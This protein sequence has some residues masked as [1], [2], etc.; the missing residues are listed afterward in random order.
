MSGIKDKNL[1]LPSS[2]T[3]PRLTYN[4]LRQHL[5]SNLVG[6]ID[7]GVDDRFK[8]NLNWFEESRNFGITFV[9][10]T[11]N[12]RDNIV[13][14]LCSI[15]N[16]VNAYLKK[17]TTANTCTDQQQYN[18][19]PLEFLIIDNG[20]TDDT[21]ITVQS[22]CRELTLDFIDLTVCGAESKRTENA[23]TRFPLFVTYTRYPFRIGK[24]GLE[25]YVTP[26]N[27]VH[28]VVY[29]T[30]WSWM[31][32]CMQYVF[33]WNADF[34]M[35]L[36][37]FEKMTQT[38]KLGQ[39]DSIRLTVVDSGGVENGEY[40]INNTH[41]LPCLMKDGFW[42]FREFVLPLGRTL[43]IFA[44]DVVVKRTRN[45]SI[46]KS[47]YEEKP[48]WC[49]FE[50]DNSANGIYSSSV[51]EYTNYMALVKSCAIMYDTVKQLLPQGIQ[52]FTRAND[53]Q[54]N[55]LLSR[56]PRSAER[57]PLFDMLCYCYDRL[58]LPWNSTEDGVMMV[59]DQVKVETACKTLLKDQTE[60]FFNILPAMRTLGNG[61]NALNCEV[62]IN[63]LSVP[64]RPDDVCYHHRRY[65]EPDA[66]NSL[67]SDAKRA[68]TCGQLRIDGAAPSTVNQ[69][70]ALLQTEENCTPK[71]INEWKMLQ[72][73]LTSG[74]TET[75]CSKSKTSVNLLGLDAA[76]A[77]LSQRRWPARQHED[78]K[79]VA[80]ITTCKRLNLFQTTIR[81][82]LRSCSDIWRIDE[83]ICADDNSSEDDREEMKNEFPWMRFIYNPP[84]T[85]GHA[86]SL[87]RIQE[88]IAKDYP[89]TEFV[90]ATEDDW[91]YLHRTDLIAQSLR[92]FQKD[93]MLGQ[94]LFVQNYQEEFSRKASMSN[95]QEK[96]RAN[97]S[98]AYV[99]H[100]HI[101]D[102]TELKQFTDRVGWNHAWW[103]GFSLRP[104]LLRMD[105]WKRLGQFDPHIQAQFEQNYAKRYFELGLRTAMLFMFHAET[106]GAPTYKRS[107]ATPNAYILN[108]TAF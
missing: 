44:G 56:V 78:V 52:L 37:F 57:M 2:N 3:S 29:Y 92:V 55:E 94:C 5:G 23:A 42:E 77:I 4:G 26:A 17:H 104:G 48:W 21:K 41:S 59:D 46:K 49:T 64:S 93:A 89:N 47:H 35:N 10:M 53:P 103:P 79:I 100:R 76:I 50:T 12:E 7:P 28:S 25:T 107:K 62:V 14:N 83:W 11:R 65:V 9:V 82:L 40:R 22:L 6:P 81:S 15:S 39:V 31:Q 20:S 45:L 66:R 34:M 108:E 87:N 80:Y 99:V 105:V 98:P 54:C 58:W 106:I 36:E 69:H 19:V 30:Q 97:A 84:G 51:P 96:W 67:S 102:P 91:V 8:I 43:E 86:A 74:V 70:H 95:E 16:T 68:I 90:F 60:S 1:F 101:T 13:N 88:T 63:M 27:S 75:D 38:L 71:Y 33:T 72:T 61:S 73:P 32:A 18:C 24:P 85:K